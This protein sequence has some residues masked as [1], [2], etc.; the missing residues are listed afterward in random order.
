MSESPVNERIKQLEGKVDQLTE[1]V[2][3]ANEAAK[4]AVFT[5][6][7]LKELVITAIEHAKQ[8][9][10]VI[11]EHIAQLDNDKDEIV[12]EYSSE[13]EAVKTKI[14]NSIDMR[15]EGHLNRVTPVSPTTGN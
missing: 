6:N 4:S 13:L 10:E 5:N 3:K 1:L 9:A 15:V 11:V 7:Q 14:I 2:N 8:N 12:K